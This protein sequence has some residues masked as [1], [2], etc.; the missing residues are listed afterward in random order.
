MNTSLIINK[1][2]MNQIPMKKGYSKLTKE[3]YQM[4]NYSNI[5]LATPILR[6]IKQEID[7]PPLED[8]PSPAIPLEFESLNDF[9]QFRM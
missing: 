7:I 5:K 6:P 2:D 9:V 3:E 8:F 1:G 4:L